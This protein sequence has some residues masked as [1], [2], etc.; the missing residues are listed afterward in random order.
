MNYKQK[1]ADMLNAAAGK[2]I[3]AQVRLDEKAEQEA[4]ATHTEVL[5]LLKALQVPGLDMASTNE[6]MI[7]AWGEPSALYIINY[8]NGF[9]ATAGYLPA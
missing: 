8:N 7:T 2:V 3:L 5:K 4:K 6:D 9:P 1:L